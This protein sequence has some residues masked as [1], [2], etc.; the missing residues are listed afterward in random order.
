MPRAGF[1]P[2]GV[3]FHEKDV[4]AE[5]ESEVIDNARIDAAPAGLARGLR[6]PYGPQ[7][8]RHDEERRL[9]RGQEQ[10]D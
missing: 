6:R 8:R 9:R 4:P 7:R 10:A 2:Q 1:R 3:P 5:L